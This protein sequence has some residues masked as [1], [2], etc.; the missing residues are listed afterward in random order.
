MNY[1]RLYSIATK[2]FNRIIKER[3]TLRTQL[4]EVLVIIK[5]ANAKIKADTKAMND[6]EGILRKRTKDE[7][8][9]LIEKYGDPQYKTSEFALYDVIS[10]AQQLQAELAQAEVLLRDALPHIEC[11]NASQSGLI[12]AIGEYLGAEQALKGD[13]T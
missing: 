4:A 7:I 6:M 10:V 5:K 9:A 13:K 1:K 3:N 8:Y 12:T 2:T 11:K